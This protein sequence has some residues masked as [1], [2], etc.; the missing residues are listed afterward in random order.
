MQGR[1]AGVAGALCAT[2]TA[3]VH[4]AHLLLLWQQAG[5]VEREDAG[6]AVLQARASVSV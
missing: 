6:Q 3:S 5:A 1:R 4:A 2:Q